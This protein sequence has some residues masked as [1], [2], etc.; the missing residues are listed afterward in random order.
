MN[1]K[2]LAF[3]YPIF[4]PDDIRLNEGVASLKSI[5]N[6]EYINDIDIIVGGWCLND[7]Y[8][9]VF[10][11]MS[12]DKAF[13]LKRFDKNYGKA[14]I[15]NDL[16]NHYLSEHPDCEYFLST[17]S[18]MILTEG[19]GNIFERLVNTATELKKMGKNFS[20]FS[21]QQTGLCCHA[22]SILTNILNING[23]EIKWGNGDGIGGGVVFVDVKFW[24]NI[25]GYRVMGVYS[26]DD[27]YLLYDSIVNGYFA[28]VINTITTYHPGT[29]TPEYL[30]WK[31]KQ[32]AKCN[33]TMTVNLNKD[34]E[35]ANEIWKI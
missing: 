33:G 20:Y 21:L 13:S 10:E 16:T 11:E 35:E 6:H 24:K 23:E 25:K 19:Q 5:L 30:E 31:H 4:C 15:I 18:D 3:F 12:K 22:H 8:W 34:I 27:G 14:Y 28:S 9:K 1:N 29:S 2:R 26:G 17:D 32:Q 7:E